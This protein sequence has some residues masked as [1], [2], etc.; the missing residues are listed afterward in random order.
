MDTQTTFDR[1]RTKLVYDYAA[2]R[3]LRSL[4]MEHF[5]EAISQST[6]RKI[7][8]ASFELIRVSRP[9]IQCFNEL[10][11]QYPRAGEHPDKPGQIVPDNMIVVHPEPIK[12]NTNFTTILQ[13][14]G[15]FLVLE[16]VSKHSVR[17]DYEISYE[18]YEKELKVPYYLVFYPDADELSLFH[19][20]DGDYRTVL[21]NRSQRFAIPELELE[22][23]L[24]EGWVRFW[25]RGELL[26]LPGDLLRQLNATQT[27]L[28]AVNSELAATEAQLTAAQGQLTAEAAARVEAEQR[29]KALE[30]E[31]AQMREQLARA[32]P[33]GA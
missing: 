12:A 32:K 14:T 10:L 6:Q 26:P 28:A 33:P 11:V 4:P 27:Q 22:V 15:P 5:M 31:L 30:A 8:V 9:D 3:Y 2:D 29:A 7:T 24:F 16:Y 17:K 19:L 13:P 20:R 23:A 1:G 18:K 21:P 25:F